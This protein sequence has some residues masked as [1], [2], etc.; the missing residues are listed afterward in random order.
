MIIKC[1]GARGSI[2]VSGKEYIKYGGS[3]TCMEVRS[4]NDEI[5]IIDAGSGIRKLGI[6]LLKEK[7]YNYSMIFTHA[8]WDHLLGFPFFQPIYSKETHMKIYGSPFAQKSV[9][10]LL[11]ISMTPPYFPVN[12][13]DIKAKISYHKANNKSFKIG[14]V[15]VISIPLSHPNG[16]MG[17]KFIEDDKVFVFL[18]DNELTLKHTGGLDYKDYMEFSSGADLLIHDSEYTE[19]DYKTKKDWGHSIYKDALKL[20]MASKVKKF[21]LFHHNQDRTDKDLDKIVRNCENIIKK[22]K[23]TLKCFAV[24]EGMQTKL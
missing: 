11:Q 2:P 18:T 16:G 17:Y 19:K 15:K 24:Y 5:I 14:S 22:T 8:H 10:D 9:E 23:S 3:T 20:A 12:Y 13:K 7:K 4:K 6:K 21:G 1:W